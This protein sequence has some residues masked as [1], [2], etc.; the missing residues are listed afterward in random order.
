MNLYKVTN[1]GKDS[2]VVADDMQSAATVWA[3]NNHYE[4]PDAI[5]HVAND[6]L[7]EGQDN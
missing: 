3:Q 5:K 6:V 1:K 4:D 2:Y 7:V